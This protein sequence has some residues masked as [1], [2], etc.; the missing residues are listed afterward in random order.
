MAMRQSLAAALSAPGVSIKE[1]MASGMVC[2]TSG[3]LETNVI[4]EPNS[5][6]ERAKPK[7]TPA[8]MPGKESGNTTVKNTRHGDAP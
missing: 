7:I 6:K 1:Y 8:K 5:P 2:V 3:I 4:V